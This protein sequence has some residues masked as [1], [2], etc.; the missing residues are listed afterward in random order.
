MQAVTL[1]DTFLA[2]TKYE[3]YCN[4]YGCVRHVHSNFAVVVAFFSLYAHVHMLFSNYS[5]ETDPCE[6]PQ[7]NFNSAKKKI[8]TLQCIQIYINTRANSVFLFLYIPFVV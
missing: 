2:L 6:F 5:D 7:A 3:W 1:M 4:V 8:I